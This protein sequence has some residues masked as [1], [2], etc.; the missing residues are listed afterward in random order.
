M[1]RKLIF[2][3]LLAPIWGQCLEEQT[4]E[5]AQPTE[6]ETIV[7]EKVLP[8]LN[9]QVV[10]TLVEG[11]NL[12][13]LELYSKLNALSGNLLISPYSISSTLA[14]A[15][16]GASGN[17][18]EVMKKI[19][20]FSLEHPNLDAAF[21]WVNR[22]LTTYT[23]DL[24][25][26]FRILSANSLWVQSGIELLPEFMQT[27]KDYYQG[28]VR[29]VDFALHPENARDSINR[30]VKDHSQG[31]I[32]DILQPSDLSRTVRLLG[33]SAL[34]M[35][36]RW[37]VIFDSK[38][39][40][41]APFFPT[42]NKSITISMMQT[43]GLFRFYQGDS[44]AILEIP[45]TSSK[46][47]GLL[48]SML[49]FLPDN[50]TSLSDFEKIFTL[51]FYKKSLVQMS[52]KQVNVYLP[53]FSISKSLILN[54]VLMALGMRNAFTSQANFSKMSK[55]T[56]LGIGKLAHKAIMTV[57]ENGIQVASG[58]GV[59]PNSRSMQPALAVFKADRPFVFLVVEKSLNTI[60]FIG[61]VSSP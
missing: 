57:N 51:D 30:W 27:M 33:A 50:K 22:V 55:A 24:G 31:Y 38:L 44:A 43:T 26:D 60:L 8:V 45:F 52:E 46:K 35:K 12:F 1:L 53:K 7:P 2:M 4:Q 9:D 42:M 29:Q 58:T 15:Y 41:Q 14:M 25:P 6:Q 47:S 13:A 59:A 3:T 18:A 5:E 40:R 34:F 61:R 23:S 21:S 17:T 32:T 48:L 56:D 54:D 10:G 49:L 37:A 19:M 16:A 11:N 39:T 36:A 20:H 28:N